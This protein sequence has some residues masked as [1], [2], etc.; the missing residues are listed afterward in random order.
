MVIHAS[1]SYEAKAHGDASSSSISSLHC[2]FHSEFEL[3]LGT[4]SCEQP[5]T[6]VH[7]PEES[8]HGTV[9]VLPRIS[10]IYAVEL[11]PE[12][13]MNRRGTVP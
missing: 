11:S 6:S 2:Y 4:L 3:S 8:D 13:S 1:Y 10:P 7:S 12:E 9:L 5:M